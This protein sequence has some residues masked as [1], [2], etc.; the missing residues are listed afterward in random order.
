[1]REAQAWLRY[2][3]I[4]RYR[5]GFEAGSVDLWL[6]TPSLNFTPIPS[7]CH[8]SLPYRIRNPLQRCGS[9]HTRVRGAPSNA[10]SHVRASVARRRGP[11]QATTPRVVVRVVHCV[12]QHEQSFQA[13]RPHLPFA[14]LSALPLAAHQARPS[15]T[16]SD[17]R[18]Y[19]RTSVP[20]AAAA[21]T[22]A[23]AATAAPMPTIVEPLPHGGSAP[24]PSAPRVHIVSP[25]CRGYITPP[26]R[27]IRLQHF[28]R[29]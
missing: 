9:L 3:Q 13:P 6:K 4:I 12:V 15:R 28:F 7:A 18:L 27:T 21:S 22:L 20:A 10:D 24:P 14:L 1:M 19:S 5:D 8:C 11:R 16:R 26:A 25:A 2:T 17:A 29:I 23:L